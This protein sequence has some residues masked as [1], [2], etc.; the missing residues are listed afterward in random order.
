[1]PNTSVFTGAD[2]SI[3]LSVPQGT[4]GERAQ[5]VSTPSRRSTSEGCRT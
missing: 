5:E 1:M 2:G 4:E 3:T